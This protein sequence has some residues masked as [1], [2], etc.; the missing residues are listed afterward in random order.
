MSRGIWM[1]CA[2]AAIAATAAEDPRT[3]LKQ[4]VEEYLKVRKQAVAGIPKLKP[5]AEPEEIAA[6]KRAQAEAIRKARV[7]AQQGAIFSA[8]VEQY[9]KSVI[10]GETAGKAG[11]PAREATKQGNPAVERPST[12]PQLKVNGTYPDS[13]PLSTV[14]PDILLRLPALPK[15]LDFRFVGKNLVL[16]DVQAGLIVDYLLN[17]L[18]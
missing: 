4:R 3:E 1:F 6:N 11:A 2:L 10:R 7:G 14:P 12:T 18:P 5:K 17:A 9:L 15:E 16:H 8:P 13:A